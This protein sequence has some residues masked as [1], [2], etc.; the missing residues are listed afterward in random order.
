MLS[1]R[2]RDAET[3]GNV[4]DLRDKPKLNQTVPIELNVSAVL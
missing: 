1:E 2:E 3:G 4:G